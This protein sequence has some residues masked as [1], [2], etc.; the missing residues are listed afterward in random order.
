MLTHAAGLDEVIHPMHKALALVE[1][2]AEAG[3]DADAALAG[4]GLRRCDLSNPAARMSARQLLAVCRNAMALTDDSLFALRAGRRIHA[5]HLGYFG[6]ALMCSATPREGLDCMRRYRALSTPIIGV[7][8]REERGCCVLTYFDSLDMPDD[9]FR[10]VLDFQ[11]GIGVSLLRDTMGNAFS[12]DAVRVSYPEGADTGGREGLLEAPI[13]FGCPENQ[14]VWDAGWLDRAQPYANSLTATMVREM[15]ERMLATVRSETGTAGIVARMLVEQPGR[16]PGIEE[17][18]QRLR[19][20]SRTLRRKLQSEG[21]SYA[22]ILASV[23]KSL[24]IEYL[25]T[26]RMKTEE[27]AE[28]LG[29]SD[30]ANFRHAFRKWTERSPSDYRARVRAGRDGVAAP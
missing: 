22:S 13:S 10:F 27:I 21:T 1:S 12:V 7:G 15:C 28:A 29:F 8:F 16:F 20:T 9:L 2:L 25:R 26:T 4:S 5:T 24:A 6:F 23:R 14:L 3:S 18:A 19:I 11:I 17:L 30:V